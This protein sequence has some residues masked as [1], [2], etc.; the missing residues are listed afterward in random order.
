M[1]WSKGSK[2]FVG[3]IIVAIVGSFIGYK[4]AYKP[5]A[6]IEAQAAAFTGDADAFKNDVVANQ[7]KWLNGIVAIKGTITDKD[8]KGIVL[9]ETIYCQFKN[10]EQIGVLSNKAAIKIKGRFIGYDDL[11]EE[12]KL[13]QCILMK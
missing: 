12:V 2:I 3:L 10:P 6:Q 9:N 11:L 1:S 8:G 13:D 4:I 7:T 5:H